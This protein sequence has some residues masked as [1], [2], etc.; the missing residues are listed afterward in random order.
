MDAIT[1]NTPT[2]ITLSYVNDPKISNTARNLIG[3]VSSA[4][5]SVFEIF[6]TNKK[7]KSKMARPTNCSRVIL[8][9][10]LV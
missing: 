5:P 6:R 8:M 7:V 3:I 2:E 9:L 4:E 10:L 1:I